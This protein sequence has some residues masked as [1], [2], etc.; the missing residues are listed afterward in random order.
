[1]QILSRLA[2]I[3]GVPVALAAGFALL[4]SRW[5]DGLGLCGWEPSGLRRELVETY[6]RRRE[7]KHQIEIANRRIEARQRVIEEVIAGRETLLG[8]AASLRAIDATPPDFEQKYPKSFP[9]N[10][11]GERLCR[12]VITRVVNVLKVQASDQ[13]GP[14]AARLEAE[15]QE[16]LRTHNGVVVLPRE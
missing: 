6:Q 13:A 15:L 16:H 8:A 2:V 9:G 10:S 7:M 14:F 1:M 12:E 3:L 4:P 11:D 5:T